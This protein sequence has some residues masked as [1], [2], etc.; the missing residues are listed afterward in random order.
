MS[1]L[2]ISEAWDETKEIFSRDGKL[3][4]SVA[5]A[6]IALPT[7]INTLVNPGGMANSSPLWKDLVG[8]AA[9][10]V[11]V[12]GQLA[13]IRLAL[14]PSVTV[15][16]AISHGLRR[17][18]VYIGAVLIILLCFALIALPLVMLALA[19]GVPLQAKPMPASPA[20][21]VI[22]LLFFAFV[23]FVAV[24]FIMS[25]AVASAEPVGPVAILKR[26]WSLTSGHFWPLLGFIILYLA[27][28]VLLL[29]AVVSATGA[30]VGLFIGSI[31]PLSAGALVLALVQ[32]LVS[33]GVSTV[34]FVMI[35][36]MYAQLAGRDA[37]QVSVPSSGI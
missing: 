33:A 1:S 28:A 25:A 9:S 7:T 29:M 2:S 11:G 21:V 34:F 27:A 26:S 6:L 32:A 20:L 36:R 37:A 3:Y 31:Q 16:G 22:S 13:L 10:L 24:R 19:V 17:L 14:G 23:L 18:P 12:A 4:V 15:G 8:L 30:V 35:A 5:L